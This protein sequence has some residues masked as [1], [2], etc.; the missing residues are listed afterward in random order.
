[1]SRGGS[2]DVSGAD[3]PG[4]IASSRP[5]A[6][7]Q[8]FWRWRRAGPIYLRHRLIVGV[9]AGAGLLSILRFADYVK[10]GQYGHGKKAEQEATHNPF[11]GLKAID[12]RGVFLFEDGRGE[13][14]DEWTPEKIREKG[15]AIASDKGPEGDFDD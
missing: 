15:A 3:T 10:G 14:P 12:Y 4:R 6:A 2:G 5:G 11:A 9:L 1:M 13:N 7:G 8:D